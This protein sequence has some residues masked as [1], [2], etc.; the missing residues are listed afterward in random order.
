MTTNH[1]PRPRVP[2]EGREAKLTIRLP[3][4]TKDELMQMFRAFRAYR[5]FNDFLLDMLIAAT[6]LAK[7]ELDRIDRKK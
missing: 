6:P 3:A 5:Y 4:E 1:F 2:H 7:S